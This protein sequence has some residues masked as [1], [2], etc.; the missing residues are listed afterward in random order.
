MRTYI[1]ATIILLFGYTA[2]AAG[3]ELP[4][5]EGE[6]AE[7]YGEV[8]HT[9]VRSAVAFY[10]VAKGIRLLLYIE[11]AHALPA[12]R[13]PLLA[14]GAALFLNAIVF[15]FPLIFIHN[16]AAI[17]ALPTLAIVFDVFARFGLGLA[18]KFQ[19]Q[20]RMRKSKDSTALYPAFNLEHL[21]ER[22]TQLVVVILG[23][24]L[25]LTTYIAGG[26]E[27]GAHQ[28]FGRS[29][30]SV[31]IALTLVSVGRRGPAL[32]RVF[33]CFSGSSCSSG[34]TSMRI[35]VERTSTRFGDTGCLAFPST[36]YTFSCPRLSSLQAL[37]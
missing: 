3:I 35:L 9:A 37:L 34:F 11:Y 15:Y 5:A 19:T 16:T 13:K 32:P 21:I 31:I 18:G 1:M 27:I 8:I 12:F 10:L 36:S 2:N 7:P 24:W 4:H 6:E 22:T 25:I 33:T 17:I 20:R 28:E 26:R 23:E 29:A 14:S 30:L